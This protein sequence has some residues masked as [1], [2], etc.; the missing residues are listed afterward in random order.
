MRERPLLV[1][2]FEVNAHKDKCMT[3]DQQ[4]SMFTQ[5]LGLK[6]EDGLFVW[7]H[8]DGIFAGCAS[9]EEVLGGSRTKAAG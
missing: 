6:D 4:E 3:V 2:F 8:Q 1:C 7:T 9:E 5:A